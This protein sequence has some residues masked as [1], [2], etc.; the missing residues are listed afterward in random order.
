MMSLIVDY[1]LY[2][3]DGE[4][5]NVTKCWVDKEEFDTPERIIDFLTRYTEK[6]INRT[7][8]VHIPNRINLPSKVFQR[9]GVLL[10]AVFNVS[11][12]QVIGTEY[13]IQ[14]ESG[15]T[16]KAV[17]IPKL[18]GVSELF[19]DEPFMFGKS[20]ELLYPEAMLILLGIR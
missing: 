20:G 12:M 7:N 2:T 8:R 16:L 17:D 10:G 13:Q 9:W 19:R 1:S 18:I 4:F 3:P 14:L 15:L 6:V 11:T 5:P